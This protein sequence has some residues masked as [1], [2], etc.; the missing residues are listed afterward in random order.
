MV[1]NCPYKDCIYQTSQDYAPCDDEQI[2]CCKELRER[3]TDDKETGRN[4]SGL[5]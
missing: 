3:R 5:C 2:A 4:H 1:E